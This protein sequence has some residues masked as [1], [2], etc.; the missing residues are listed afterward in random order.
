MITKLVFS[1]LVDADRYDSYLFEA[2]I[3]PEKD[4]IPD[5]SSLLKNLEKSLESLNTVSKISLIRKNVSDECLYAA[6][7]EQGVY[8]L[9]L[10]TG[11]GK[12]LSGLR[13]A[14]AHAQKHGLRHIIY[15]IP[16]LSILEQTADEIRSKLN[17]EIDSD[18]LLEHHSNI[19]SSEENENQY[20]LLTS[21][22][23]SPIIVT[24][25]VQFLESVFSN[26]SGD[27]R[28]LHNM[29]ESVIIFDE[30]QN[31]PVKCVYLFNEAIN[32]LTAFCRNTV[33]LCSATQP[34][35]DRIKVHNIRLSANPSLIKRSTSDSFSALKRTEVIF[36]GET[37]CAGVAEMAIKCF[38]NGESCLVIVNTKKCAENIF[39]DLKKYNV[40]AYHLSTNMCREH[41]VSVIDSVK[42]DLVSKTPVICI[43]TQLIEAGVDISFG[44]VIRSLAGLDSIAQ[45]AGRCNRSGEYGQ[46]KPVYV[47]KLLGENLSKLPDIKIGA[48]IS[49]R[50]F[51]EIKNGDIKTD[52]PLSKT[53][54]DKYYERYFTERESQ[55]GYPADSGGNSIFGM[56]SLNTVGRN[57]L[58][59]NKLTMPVLP[60]AFE[61]AGK[62]FSVIGQ[63][64]SDVIV[65]GFD[66]NSRVLLA[67]Y[68]SAPIDS[69]RSLLRKL[70]KYSVSLW[71][72]Q[73]DELIKKG[74]ISETDDGI[75]ILADG[76]YDSETGLDI[77]GK[78]AALII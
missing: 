7:R 29:T 68:M 17:I 78:H 76:F 4:T 13:F 62:A 34:V 52:D 67:K 41:R 22:W 71:S 33:L 19:I 70:G 27:L 44:C 53:A 18:L 14:L 21:R 54:L 50:I 35:L 31:L 38:E 3:V 9:E 36:K 47:V 61:A 64:T 42:R 1:A 74:A 26:K 66:D 72:Y 60:Y 73:K 16:Y 39:C 77:S 6:D 58:I 23:D 8:K 49:D 15:V 75:L 48:E 40:H 43:S 24:T 2:C 30:I 11:G 46:T 37:D 63:D 10:H 55:F 32:F 12:T 65:A 57:A 69:R 45:A 28:K 25:M 51:R 59:E 5:W 20:R 56:L